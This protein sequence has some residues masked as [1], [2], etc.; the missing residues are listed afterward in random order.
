MTHGI[1]PR[2]PAKRGKICPVPGRIFLD[3]YMKKNDFCQKFCA[4]FS[5]PVRFSVR[6]PH[7]R[8]A[9]K[10]QTGESSCH[11]WRQQ[12]KHGSPRR[13]S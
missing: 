12:R 4:C 5:R 8:L 6:W 9:T 2:A 1:A 10:D 13:L 7:D 3:N 11:S